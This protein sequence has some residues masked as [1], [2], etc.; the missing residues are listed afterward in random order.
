MTMGFTTVERR[1]TTHSPKSTLTIGNP[2]YQGLGSQDLFLFPLIQ[3]TAA[4][5]G[6]SIGA[7][8]SERRRRLAACD[9]SATSGEDAARLR[10]AVSAG[11]SSW[12]SNRVRTERLA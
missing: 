10:G 8:D 6:A 5:S 2:T 9:A 3:P 7:E 1:H 4:N 11:S 12:R